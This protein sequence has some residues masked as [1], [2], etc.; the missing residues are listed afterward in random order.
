MHRWVEGLT[1]SYSHNNEQISPQSEN[2]EGQEQNKKDFLLLW[3]LCEAQEDKVNY[4]VPGFHL[5]CTEAEFR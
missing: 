4:I 1:D 2:V 5:V 3:I